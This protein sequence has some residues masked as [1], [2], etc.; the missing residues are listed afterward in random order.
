VW[1]TPLEACHPGIWLQL[2][3][4][5]DGDVEANRHPR[6]RRDPRP[7]KYDRVGVAVVD[8]PLEVD[9]AQPSGGLAGA[10][11]EPC[12]ICVVVAIDL[13]VRLPDVPRGDNGVVQ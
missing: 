8:D 1:L 12:P 10:I 13:S 5:G 4:I 6:L 9:I 3:D 11:G 2:I 7:P